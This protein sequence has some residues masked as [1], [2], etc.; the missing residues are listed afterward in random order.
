MTQGGNEWDQTREDQRVKEPEKVVE[1]SESDGEK[2]LW[3]EEETIPRGRG[4][5]PTF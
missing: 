1:Q 4:V 3:R 5:G 2:K